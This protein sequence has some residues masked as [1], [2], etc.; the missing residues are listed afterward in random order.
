[1]SLQWKNDIQAAKSANYDYRYY[2]KIVI[3]G[4]SSTYYPV[5]FKGGDQTVQRDIIIRRSFNEQAPSDWNN[6]STTHMGGLNLLIKTNF[7][8]RGGTGY[9]WDIYDLQESYCHMF[10]GAGHCGNYCM[11][12]VFLRG[13]GG[14]LR[15]P[16]RLVQ[17]AIAGGSRSAARERGSPE[18]ITLTHDNYGTDDQRPALSAGPAAPAGN[19]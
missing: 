6:G 3:N 19:I 8:C 12:A 1:M 2:K 16:Q 5:V 15:R 18:H 7:G 17:P 14:L 13:G 10:G 11:F 4:D 9:S